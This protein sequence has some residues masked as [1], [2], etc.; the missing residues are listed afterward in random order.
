MTRWT[1]AVLVIG[2]VGVAFA[3]P[4]PSAARTRGC[5]DRY[6]FVETEGVTWAE[7]EAAARAL[8]RGAHL[9]TISTA[10]EAACVEAAIP[11]SADAWIGGTDSAVEGQWRW[12]DARRVFFF[13]TAD[14]PGRSVNAYTD[15]DDYYPQ[16]DDWDGEGPDEDCLEVWGPHEPGLGQTWNDRNCDVRDPN[17]GFVVEFERSR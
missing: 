4:A 11:S 12:I 9:A 8:G 16:P 1:L 7:A 5:G 15:W 3:F 13:G 10:A 17:R 14:D 2:C 6:R